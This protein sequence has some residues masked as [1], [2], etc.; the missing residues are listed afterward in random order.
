VGH[1][2]TGTNVEARTGFD[3][4][5][6]MLPFLAGFTS[7]AQQGDSSFQAALPV[8]VRQVY[9][10]RVV[11]MMAALWLPV[12]VS[13]VMARALPNAGFPIGS[14]LERMS[15]VTAAMLGLQAMGIRGFKIL[16]PALVFVLGMAWSS[17]LAGIWDI[18]V[19][20]VVCALAALG[21]FLWTW[22][23]VPKTFQSAPLDV[24]RAE[25]RAVASSSDRQSA[26]PWMPVLRTVFPWGGFWII[27]PFV[28]M[29]LGTFRPYIF[30]YAGG[31]WQSTRPAVRWLFTL[32]VRRRMVLNGILFAVLFSFAGGY[33]VSVHLPSI[34]TSAFRT[35]WLR[36]Y[37]TLPQWS[38]THE[39]S[40]C[41]TPSVLPPIDFWFVAKGQV[42]PIEA[43]WGETFQ[44][45]VFRKTGFD[46]Y[47]PY[48]VGCEN[49]ER[50][51]DWQF[52]R[53]TEAVY[54][55]RLPRD[56]HES[57]QFGHVVVTSARTQ[58]VNVA[59]MTAFAMLAVMVA[60]LN[61]WYRFRRIPGAVRIT[62]MSLPVGAGVTLM[63]LDSANKLPI[64]QWVSWVLPQSLPAA[65]LTAFLPL[66]LLYCLLVGLFRQVEIADKTEGRAA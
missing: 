55:R 29:L 1:F 8:T 53:A 20:A 47:N 64:T 43:P 31:A 59:V 25:K 39:T 65:I 6:F 15:A 26:Y 3:V 27:L 16:P 22:R 60:L 38:G 11:S 14:L 23:T 18:A 50:F 48:A 24:S 57:W 10:S 32:P 62:L 12:I 51:L 41:K 28:M 13:I 56:Q 30:I 21:T 36:T 63:L 2:V 9:L 54:G 52:A 61:D 58:F 42:P 37:Q 17:S 66:A 19:V 40:G 49:S 34:P 45:P 7:T 33:L 44:P 35:I 5:Y 46:I 4:A